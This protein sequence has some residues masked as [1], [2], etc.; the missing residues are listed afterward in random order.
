[1]D[2]RP[3]DKFYHNLFNY[4]S[5]MFC[6]CEETRHCVITLSQ[7]QIARSAEVIREG[8]IRS[9]AR[10]LTADQQRVSWTHIVMETEM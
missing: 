4:L 3:T 2:D 8:Y 7:M 9:E 5:A 1:M 10:L 6:I